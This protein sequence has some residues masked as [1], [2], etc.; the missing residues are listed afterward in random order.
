MHWLNPVGRLK[1]GVTLAQAEQD[2]LAV[3]ARIADVDSGVEA[4]LER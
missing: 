2:V 3:R 1:P 4:R